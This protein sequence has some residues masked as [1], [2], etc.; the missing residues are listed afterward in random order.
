MTDDKFSKLLKKLLHL[1]DRWWVIDMTNTNEDSE[2]E[3]SK[4]II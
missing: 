2:D 3:D 1:K 4:I